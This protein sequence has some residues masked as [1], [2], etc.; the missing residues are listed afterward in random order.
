M[1][2]S[3][4]RSARLKKHKGQEFFAVEQDWSGFH[5]IDDRT[6]VFGSWDAV[7][8][9]LD[10]GRARPD[11]PLQ[12][13][14]Q[15]A[16]DKHH[17]V[18]GFNPAVLP[19]EL[20]AAAQPKQGDKPA[21]ADLLAHLPALLKAKCATLTVDITNV[22]KDTRCGLK[23]DFADEKQADN[24]ARAG[25]SLLNSGAGLARHWAKEV[26]EQM[27]H[28][29]I[30]AISASRSLRKPASSTGIWIGSRRTSCNW[31]RQASAA[32]WRRICSRCLSY[33]TGPMWSLRKRRF[34]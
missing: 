3:E 4:K 22:S 7:Y 20:L 15:T 18:A 2:S 24:A 14:L 1:P 28:P 21:P 27:K 9:F 17:L 5:F 11:G 31:E 16:A 32:T 29:G 34:P 19:L 8:Q 6:F 10:R 25:R 12:A 13:A 26:E 23:L 33:C 30:P